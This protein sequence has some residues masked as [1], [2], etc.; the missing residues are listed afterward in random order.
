MKSTEK[1]LHYILKKYL[2]YDA[3]FEA[4]N[5]LEEYSKELLEDSVEEREKG[6]EEAYDMIKSLLSNLKKAE[7]EH[8]ETKMKLCRFTGIGYHPIQ[9]EVI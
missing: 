3:Y 1:H 6:F 8:E 4:C 9:G 7:Q 2:P 5:A